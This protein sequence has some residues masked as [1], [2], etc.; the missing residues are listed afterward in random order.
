MKGWVAA[1]PR[2]WRDAMMIA[3][4]IQVPR[5]YQKTAHLVVAGMGGSGMGGDLLQDLLRHDPRGPIIVNHTYDLPGW[6]GSS[7]VVGLVSYSGD[8]EETLAVYRAARSRK[9][10]VF[11]ITSGGR[12]AAMA[13]R[14]RVPLAL[15]PSGYPPRAALGYTFLSLVKVAQR[16]GWGPSLWRDAKETASR[17]ERWAVSYERGRT[18]RLM[19]SWARR[20]AGQPVLIMTTEDRR[21][22]GLRWKNQWN[23]N[24]KSLAYVVTLP[25]MDHNEVV[26]WGHSMRSHLRRW[27][28]VCL[29]DRRDHSRIQMRFGI[30]RAMWRKVGGQSYEVWSE[31]QSPMARAMS[32]IYFGDW[33]SV[34]LA[35]VGGVA[36]TP[37]PP[38]T[39]L[40]QQLSRP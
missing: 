24:A 36:A 39:W 5:A 31:G 9:A 28:L 32:H 22:V 6:V 17:L 27:T 18:A 25:E 21:S 4:A 3:E 29:R 38:I 23:E 12:L 1:F 37:V 26:G 7:S 10:K 34:Y 30:T 14:D 20:W 16:L 8:T 35:E 40:K 2:Q 11:C 13:A 15:I 33:L 19:K